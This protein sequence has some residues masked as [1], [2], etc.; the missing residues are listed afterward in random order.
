MVLGKKHGTSYLPYTFFL[1][2][3]FGKIEIRQKP[4]K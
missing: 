1:K 3:I 4:H 2:V